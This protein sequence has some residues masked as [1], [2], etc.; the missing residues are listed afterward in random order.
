MGQ[1]CPLPL[2]SP[3]S[4]PCPQP[5][6]TGR[7]L[8]VSLRFIGGTGDSVTNLSLVSLDH[9]GDI[10]NAPRWDRGPPG[11]PGLPRR[12]DIQVSSG[13]TGDTPVSPGLRRDI[14]VSPR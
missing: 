14:L 2:V 7:R 13:R 11:V 1:G 5:P 10:L 6:V 3:T 9:K 12:R 4:L 8:S